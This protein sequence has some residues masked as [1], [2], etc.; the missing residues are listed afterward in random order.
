M[1]HMAYY[2]FE[3]PKTRAVGREVFLFTAYSPH[4]IYFFVIILWFT[5]P[6]TQKKKEISIQNINKKVKIIESSC[7]H[8]S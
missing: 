2:I 7:S 6:I 8:P 1:G 3:P 5:D 4:F